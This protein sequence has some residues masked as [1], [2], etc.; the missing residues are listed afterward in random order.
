[1]ARYSSLGHGSPTAPRGMASLQFPGAWLR[2]SS[3]GH[4]SPAPRDMA[5]LQLLR[6]WL[7]CSSSGHGSP[8]A[9]RGMASLQLLGAWLLQ[10]LGAWLPLQ[11]PPLE[12]GS[13]YMALEGV[14]QL[15]SWDPHG[16]AC[17]KTD[18]QPKTA[19]TAPNPPTAHP[20]GSLQLLF[21]CVCVVQR[22]L[23]PSRIVQLG[24][25]SSE[26]GGRQTVCCHSW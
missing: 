1:M 10:L 4:G 21:V 9:P 16:S 3:S 26:E 19:I 24:N 8:A 22:S 15:L 18:M 2:Y 23:V 5:P 14:A 17:L 6:A 20:P 25:V 13:P 12:H 11:L 7:P